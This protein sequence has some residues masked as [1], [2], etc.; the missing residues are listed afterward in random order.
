ML[1]SDGRAAQFKILQSRRVAGW[2]LVGVMAAILELALLR[3]LYEVVQLAL[4]IATAIAAEVLILVK[5]GVSDRW[6]FGHPWPS[7]DRLVRYHG[8]CFG[9]LLVYWL[10]INGLSALLQVPYIVGFV[11]GTAASFAWSLITNF[12]WVWAR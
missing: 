5:F 3:I 2:F 4:P 9:A 7:L 12:F 10:V 1:L 11:L 6:V 8:A